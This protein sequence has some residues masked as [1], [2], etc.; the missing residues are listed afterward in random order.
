MK[1]PKSC[2]CCYGAM[3]SHWA[4]EAGFD[5]V[6]CGECGLLYVDPMPDSKNVESADRNSWHKLGGMMVNVRSRQIRR[7][8]AIYYRLI[9]MMHREVIDAGKPNY[10]G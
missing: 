4:E 3:R 7:K 5:V 10:L 1:L 6:R 9:S 8:V 2:P